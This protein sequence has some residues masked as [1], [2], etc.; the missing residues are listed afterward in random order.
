LE[1]WLSIDIGFLFKK[2]ETFEKCVAALAQADPDLAEYLRRTRFW[3]EPLL[4]SRNDLEHEIGV[5]S[6]ITY[7]PLDTGVTVG[8]PVVAGMPV[9]QFMRHSFDRLIC[10]IEEFTAHC[11]QRHMPTGITIT[12]IAPADRLKEAPERFRIALVDGGF[13]PWRIAFHASLFEDV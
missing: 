12:E 1:N 7:T 6:R 11:L 8:E 5:L 13:A 4:K 10:F 3:S 9:T 2:R